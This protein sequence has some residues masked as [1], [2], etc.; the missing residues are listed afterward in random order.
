MSD[1]PTPPAPPIP[2]APPVPPAPG[3]Q[4]RG[5]AAA[6]ETGK[7]LAG[8]GYIVWVV[9]LVTLLVEPY[10]NEPLVRFHAAQALALWAIVTLLAIPGVGWIIAT[11]IAV[12]AI[13]AAVNAFQG[14]YYEV[15]VLGGLLKDW[16]GV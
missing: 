16:F 8:V 10:K 2:P 14:K 11:V 13:I 5:Y 3:D 4:A 15:P 12:F 7:I 9:A 1:I 6:S